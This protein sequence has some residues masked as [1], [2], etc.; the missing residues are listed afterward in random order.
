MSWLRTS[1]QEASWTLGF[2]PF[3]CYTIEASNVNAFKDEQNNTNMS[4]QLKVSIAC[5]ENFSPILKP[6]MGIARKMT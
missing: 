2:S 6:Y 3:P 1:I 4:N 5:E